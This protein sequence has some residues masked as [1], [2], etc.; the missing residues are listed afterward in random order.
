MKET[1]RLIEVLDTI[2]GAIDSGNGDSVR[3]EV[4]RICKGAKPDCYGI[5]SAKADTQIERGCANC[6]IFD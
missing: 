1:V 5:F 2:A 3:Y 4:H 6:E